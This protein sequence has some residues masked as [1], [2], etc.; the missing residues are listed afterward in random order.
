[1]FTLSDDIF[2]EKPVRDMI[3]ALQ[4]LYME[5]FSS[6]SNQSVGIGEIDSSDIARGVSSISR[7]SLDFETLV[8]QRYTSFIDR[9]TR[10]FAAV[11]Y[12]DLVFS[13]QIAIYL[14]RSVPDDLRL[15]VW[16][17]LETERMLEFLPP[18]EKCAGQATVYLYPAEVRDICSYMFIFLLSLFANGILTTGKPRDNK[19][20]CICVGHR[21]P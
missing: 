4:E 5:C 10:Q 7:C 14:T 19:V 9:L 2:L 12:G 17:S 16:K 6:G 18:I 15:R 3:G 13:R 8:D 21:C 20:L 1:V 11:S